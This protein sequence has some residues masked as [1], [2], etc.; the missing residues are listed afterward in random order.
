MRDAMK[1][2]RW[3]VQCRGTLDTLRSDG[4]NRCDQCGREVELALTGDRE[5][6]VWRHVEDGRYTCDARVASCGGVYSFRAMR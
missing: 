5:W 2:E 6:V 3:T 4:M 1:S